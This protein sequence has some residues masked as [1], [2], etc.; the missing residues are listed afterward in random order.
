MLAMLP[1]HITHFSALL[2]NMMI[3]SE[4]KTRHVSRQANIVNPAIDMLSLNNTLLHLYDCLQRQGGGAQ[5]A[6]GMPLTKAVAA[7]NKV[8]VNKRRAPLTEIQG[9]C[10]VTTRC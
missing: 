6:R 9:F 7:M 3:S 8:S 4:E 10:F 1:S 2:A 5:A